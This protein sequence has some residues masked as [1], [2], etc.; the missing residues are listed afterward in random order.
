[1]H[2]RRLLCLFGLLWSTV[3]AHSQE[4]ELKGVVRDLQGGDVAFATVYLYQASDTTLL[5]TEMADELGAFRFPDIPARVYFLRASYLGAFSE[6]RAI[7]VSSD[8]DAGALKVSMQNELEE[9][10]VTGTV[11]QI[12]REPGKVVFKVENTVLSTGSTADILSRAPGVIQQGGGYYLRGQPA[13][14]FING[15]QVPLSSSEAQDLLQGLSG[16]NVQAVEVIANP[17]AQYSADAGAVLNV[18]TSR[19]VTPGYK[20]SLDLAY[21]QA[22]FAKYRFGLSQYFKSKKWNL[23]LGYTFNPNNLANQYDASTLYNPNETPRQLWALEGDNNLRRRTSNLNG[24]VE[25]SLSERSSLE[26]AF[27]LQLD[28]ARSSNSFYTND[29]TDPDNPQAGL[30]SGFNTLSRTD[31]DL[32]NFSNDLAYRLTGEH[33]SLKWITNWTRYAVD[34]LQDLR[35]DYFDGERSVE[36]TARFETATEQ[37]IEILTTQV[38]WSTYLDASSIDAG[39]RF[40]YIGSD[41][42]IDYQ[43]FVGDSPVVDENDSDDFAY[44]ERV[45]AAYVNFVEG[46]WD[47]WALTTGLRVEHTNS[48]GFSA[49]LGE[50]ARFNFTEL[51]PS[52][53][54]LYRPG[55]KFST[56]FDYQRGI[57]RPNYRD[58]NPFRYFVTE[59]NV[60]N[61]NP[62]LQP[63]FFNNYTLN[64]TFNDEF[65]LDFYLYDNGR[66]ISTL[67][68]QEN[69]T[70]IVR[71]QDQNLQGSLSY[72]IDFVLSK[73]L[74][75]WWYLYSY[76]SLFHEEETFIAEESGGVEFTNDF[77]GVFV[78]I[79]NYLD[80]SRDR[81]WRA[82]IEF[83]YLSGLISG[84]YVD[85]AHNN[86]KIGITKSL[87]DNRAQLSIQAEDLLGGAN[88]R[89]R[90]VYLNQNNNFLNFR[91]MQFVRFGFRYNFGNFRLKGEGRNIQS[92]EID[93]LREE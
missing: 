66:Y 69:D 70:F 42:T 39:V 24:L 64:F 85:D 14:I 57:E 91:E 9:V 62:Q 27:N 54:L 4:F 20:G 65:F 25:F 16:A 49:L 83:E 48:E 10:V 17:G 31:G 2:T 47:K 13:E 11:P 68:F 26:Y 28:P 56:S 86:L 35:T 77:D 79:S 90:S 72:G 75:D 52:L 92:D 71:E 3:F 32:S 34:D 58:L 61:G 45:Y 40:S 5:R 19:N 6:F 44:L 59:V 76:A 74:T 63:S 29:I 37:E 21:T 12:S 7:D 87:W 46:G 8:T 22:I 82:L 15:R 51:F 23:F 93:R 89:T 53:Q 38:D 36:R 60:I 80:L 55:E 88:F 50:T 33:S 43:G 1:M 30:L 73:P 18:I 41:N 67:V 81:S 78:Q 84:S